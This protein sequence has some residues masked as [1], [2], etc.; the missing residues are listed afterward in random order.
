MILR[1]FRSLPYCFDKFRSLGACGMRCH[2]FVEARISGS[3]NF[4]KYRCKTF[5]VHR[6]FAIKFKTII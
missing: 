3:T 4:Y 6:R 2:I 5:F 1:Y